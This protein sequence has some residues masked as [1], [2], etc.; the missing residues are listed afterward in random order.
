[1]Y[2][3]S[4]SSRIESINRTERAVL[5]SMLRD[6]EV[7]DEVAQIVRAEDFRTDAHGMS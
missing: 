4:E 6:N 3:E 5:G 2:R 7:I 1:M